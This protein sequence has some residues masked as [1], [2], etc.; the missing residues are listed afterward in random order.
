MLAI[1]FYREVVA[2]CDTLWNLFYRSVGN[3]R[4]ELK[5]ATGSVIGPVIGG[6][7]T[8]HASRR[9]CVFSW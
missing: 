1:A 8:Q 5:F 3:D 7:L 4:F 9:G 6:A 2:E